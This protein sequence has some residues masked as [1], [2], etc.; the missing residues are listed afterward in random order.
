MTLQEQLAQDINA[1]SAE[2][3]SETY[4]G[5]DITD[6]S[7]IEEMVDYII[8]DIDYFEEEGDAPVKR[9]RGRPKGTTGI[10]KR[11]A[12]EPEGEK[13]EPRGIIQ[14]L[15]HAADNPNGAHVRFKNGE[16]HHVRRQ[17]A[18]KALL[19][20]SKPHN[21]KP[22]AKHALATKLG[23][24]KEH[25]YDALKTGKGDEK[26]GVKK[27]SLARGMSYDPST[28]TVAKEEFE[29]IDEL[30]KNT[31]KSYVDKSE[32]SYADNKEKFHVAGASRDY[33]GVAHSANQIGKRLNG[34]KTAEKKLAAEGYEGSEEDKAEDKKEEKKRGLSHKEWE[35]S[36]A[37]KK[38]DKEG[39]KKAKGDNLPG[40]QEKLDKNKNGKLDKEDFK[41][42]RKEEFNVTPATA[43]FRM[44]AVENVVRDIMAKNVDLRRLAQEDEFNKRNGQ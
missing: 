17:E 9:G 43:D 13:P 39:E 19:H 23:K 33:A 30:S 42:L 11:R 34:L 6:L 1:L 41:K 2:E 7:T 37:D 20:F 26:P 10:A 12:G 32:K 4:A 44:P 38:K 29:Q 18:H 14:Q 5:I 24:S 21:E 8:E 16:A 40:D 22:E 31:L 35:K 15:G 36:D 28:K 25:F 27:I 3:F